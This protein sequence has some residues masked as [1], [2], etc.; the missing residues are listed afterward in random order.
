MS[1]F[2]QLL[3]SFLAIV[4]FIVVTLVIIIVLVPGDKKEKNLTDNAVMKIKFNNALVE[5]ENVSLQESVFGGGS[6]KTG[7]IELIKAIR[8][9]KEDE[10]IK[11][12]YLE[13]NEMRAGFA[14]LE[15]LRNELLEF[16]KSGKFITTYAESYSEGAYYLAS[17]ADKIVLPSGGMVEFN[18]L[19]SEILFYK[20]TLDKLDLKVEVFRVGSYKSFVE[21]F[22][23]ENMSPENREQIKQ[24]LGSMYSTVLTNI[25]KSRGIDLPTLSNISDSMLVRN[26]NDALRLKIVTDLG[27]YDVLEKY[28]KEKLEAKEEEKINYISYKKVLEDNKLK[29]LSEGDNKI[30]IIVASGE[31][32]SGRGDNESI[33]SESITEQLRKA[34]NDDKVKAVV[35]RINSPG[36]SA[37]ASD[38]IWNEINQLKAKK[39][40][41]A[42]MSD[43]AASGGY[44]MAMAC[45]TI[46]AHPNTITGSIGVFGLLL[47]ASVFMKKNLGITSDRE[48]TGQFSDVGT[49]NRPITDYERKV[50]QEE[51]NLIYKDFTTKA[52]ESRKMKLEDLEK[53]AG[54]RVWSGLD[55]KANG[56]VDVLG[57]MNIAVELATKAA[58]LKAEDVKVVYWPEQKSSFLKEVITNMNEEEAKAKEDYSEFFA[59]YNTLTKLKKQQGVQAKLP[60]ELVVE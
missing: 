16:K 53:V 45:D 18:G 40:V 38:V 21:P 31:I 12:L 44:Y 9:A 33:G 41:I 28:F 59:T 15:E 52:A 37:L 26:S 8:L 24:F 17:V 46:V 49:I 14:S 1:F 19:R 32:N 57:G 2:K 25:S 47:D 39:P 34:K 51:V 50:I 54:G 13:L 5:R 10:K 55:A 60:F 43:V 22:L 58:G 36:G 3:A 30:A 11:G 56:L 42:S 29:D 4:L 35:L 48:R 23:R 6:D 20:G 7:L 27:Y